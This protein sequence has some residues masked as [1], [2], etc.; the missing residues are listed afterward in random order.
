MGRGIVIVFTVI[1]LAV[2]GVNVN[3]LLRTGGMYRDLVY[4][5][6]Q[7]CTPIDGMAGPED[8][9]M[10]GPYAIV[11]SDDRRATR[12]AKAAGTIEGTQFGNLYAL[13]MRAENPNPLQLILDGPEDFHP[14]G[15]SIWQ[16]GPDTYRLFLINH[17]AAGGHTVELYD[18]NAG[19][20]RAVHVETIADPHML[21]PND[22]V[23]TG[24]RSFYFTN[25]SGSET[26][27]GG[28]VES[29]FLLPR[30]QVG[31][32]DGTAARFV[33][34]DMVLANGI[35]TSKD[36]TELYVSELGRAAIRF[37]DIDPETMDVKFRDIIGINTN[38]DNIDVA[39][40]GSLWV[41]SHVN[42][43]KF[44]AY[45]A[46]DEAL[47]PTHILKITLDR[48]KAKDMQSG[49]AGHID[50]VMLTDG[51]DISASTV[52]V[53]YGDRFLIGSVM[54]SGILMCGIE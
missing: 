18:W 11:S 17:P 37:Y 25:D 26:A 43:F 6:P 42:I 22:L 51:S 53:P 10:A 48:E 41:G 31:Y 38:P 52:G 9:Q 28:M 16:M 39:E 54:D 23:A 47:A 30:A 40:D 45:A 35:N 27:L 33:I 5:A 15:L 19:E 1:V 4:H 36:G 20:A 34:E 14:H 12:A 32:Y 46:D 13:D 44:L 3:N 21:S 2:I 8:I 50:E 24:P 29:L 49:L 7:N